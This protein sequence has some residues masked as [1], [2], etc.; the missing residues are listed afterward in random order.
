MQAS[1]PWVTICA[2]SQRG[3]C[4]HLCVFVLVGTKPVGC[5]LGR[6]E[7]GT[8]SSLRGMGTKEHGPGATW[9]HTA[10]NIKHVPR[11]GKL[12]RVVGPY[13][14]AS[15]VSPSLLFVV[16]DCWMQAGECLSWAWALELFCG[17]LHMYWPLGSLRRVRIF[18]SGVYWS[19]R[20]GASGKAHLASFS[21]PANERPRVLFTLSLC[22][23]PSNKANLSGGK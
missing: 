7:R 5:I 2:A 15:A 13:A 3:V 16:A 21:A 8:K 19:E 14:L 12:L 9:S 1:C 10:S 6:K 11:L 23:F 4:T 20:G 18:S 17:T 22:R